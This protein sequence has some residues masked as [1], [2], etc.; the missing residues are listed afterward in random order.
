MCCLPRGVTV[1]ITYKFP[2]ILQKHSDILLA[3]WV[4][5]QHAAIT[6]RRDHQG[7]RT[8]AAIKRIP[9]CLFKKY[10]IRNYW[11]D[12]RGWMERDEVLHW[13]GFTKKNWTWIYCI[14]HRDFYILLW[15][16]LLIGS[17]RVRDITKIE[18]PISHMYAYR[19]D[20]QHLILSVLLFWD[21]H[22]PLHKRS[23]GYF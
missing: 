12:W 21:Q 17:D 5:E 22:K 15:Y 23:S 3:D 7:C 18:G 16:R 6:H 2:E 19:W 1:A 8:R 11:T 4:K 14:R 13:R 20:S 10:S 9:E